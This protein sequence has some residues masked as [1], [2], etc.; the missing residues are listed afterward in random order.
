M[1]ARE[2]VDRL[3][4]STARSS[5]TELV[6]WALSWLICSSWNSHSPWTCCLR[7]SGVRSVRDMMSLSSGIVARP[8]SLIGFLGIFP[9]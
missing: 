3:R 2:C 9:V 4:I 1:D 7:S 5:P 6:S 8:R